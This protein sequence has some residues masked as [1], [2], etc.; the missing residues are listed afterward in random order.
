[1][2]RTRRMTLAVLFALLLSSGAALADDGGIHLEQAWA[3]ATPGGAKTGAIYLTV[4]NTG[5]AS[6]TLTAASTPA[7]DKAQLHQ[8]T[9]A[10][11]V[12]EMRPV[13]ALAIASGQ[14]IVLD[15]ASGYHI[16]LTGLKAPL[17]EGDKIPLTLTFEHAG[18]QQIMA[19]VGKI[20]AMHAGDTSAMPGMSMPSGTGSRGMSTM[21]GM[22]H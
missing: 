3:R 18:T 12:M 4:S 20:G 5:I 15:P 7:A 11:G 16:M 6:D 19:S 1:M 10:N 22:Q 13:P 17:K 21:P 2:K 9:M 14:S 8:M